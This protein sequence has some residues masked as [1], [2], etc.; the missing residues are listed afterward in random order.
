MSTRAEV[1]APR[2]Q[3]A[4]SRLPRELVP[5]VFWIGDCFVWPPRPGQ[6]PEHVYNSTYLVHG[7]ERS[8][9]VDTGHPND[10]E[11]VE[12]LL[13]GLVARGVPPVEWIFP[14]HAEVTHA[15]NLERL[16][17]KYPAARAC[18]DIRDLHLLFPDYV[19][20]FTNVGIGDSVDLGERRFVFVEAVFRDLAA[21]LWG[22]DEGQGVLFSGDGLGFGHVHE[23]EQC[24][25]VAEEIPGM[26]ISDLTEL[27]AEYALYWTRLKTVEPHIA[28]LDALM[29]VE[30][31]VNA[32]APAHGSP[33]CDPELTMPKVREGLRQLA[34][35]YRLT[36]R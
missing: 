25:K 27:F 5:G 3:T 7:T 9:L 10:W 32:I 20:R 28:R 18:A 12:P 8:L 30:Y 16:L 15:G 4:G 13:D 35:K 24:G 19:D 17:A 11:V 26:P 34:S 23:A 6:P 22:Y 29:N 36:E 31:R 14:T 2:E 21:T 1:L 33:V